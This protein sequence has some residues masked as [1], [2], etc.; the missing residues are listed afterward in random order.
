MRKSASRG[1]ARRFFLALFAL[2]S[3]W[4]GSTP[5]AGKDKAA[6][7]LTG[8]VAILASPMSIRPGGAA[9]ILAASDEAFDKAVLRIRGPS[10]FV[11]AVTSKSGG[12]PPFWRILEFKAGPEGTYT[13]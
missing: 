6:C 3:A 11:D 13:V 9:R 5:A 10:G 1:N 8:P 2:N 12:G 4:A 7:L